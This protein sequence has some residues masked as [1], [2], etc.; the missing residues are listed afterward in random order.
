MTQVEIKNKDGI[1]EIHISGHAENPYPD[2]QGNLLC[3]SISILAY[4]LM[5]TVRD[6][7]AKGSLK[8]CSESCK[9]GEVQVIAEP[10]YWS[11]SQLEAKI[12]VIKTGYELLERQFPGM[13]HVGGEMGSKT[14]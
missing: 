13:V 6:L 3:A 4:T 1:W 9:D 2:M 14:V 8:R 10:E 5:Q 12:G 11:E 7:K